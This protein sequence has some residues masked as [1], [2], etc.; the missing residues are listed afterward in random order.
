MKTYEE[1]TRSVF[2]RIEE[3]K[4][5]QRN[6]RRTITK[7]ATPILSFCLVA[8]LGIG[9]WQTGVFHRAPAITDAGESDYDGNYYSAGTND[10]QEADVD[11]SEQDSAAKEEL[12][13]T[14]PLISSYEGSGDGCYKAPHDGEVYKS[15]PLKNA[16][17]AYGDSANYHVLVQIFKDCQPLNGNSAEV[18]A[19]MNRLTTM[20]CPIVFENA[21]SYAFSMQASK[22]QIQDLSFDKDYGYM[23][24]LYGEFEEDLS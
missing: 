18:Q 3:E 5:I 21:S 20:G 6:Q 9:A 8:I 14:I 11:V 24:Y 12:G 17:E 4:E 2:N 10:A 16:I 22:D 13:K 1:K 19:E 7:I 15:I 23:V